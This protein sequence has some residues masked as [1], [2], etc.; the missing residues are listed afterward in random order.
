MHVEAVG[1]AQSGKSDHHAADFL[2]R[3]SSG[4]VEDVVDKRVGVVAFAAERLDKLQRLLKETVIALDSVIGDGRAEA[5]QQPRL[6]APLK[7]PCWWARVPLDDVVFAHRP[8]GVSVPT[9][10]TAKI[11]G[12]TVA[13]LAIRAWA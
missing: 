3:F 2:P 1:E 5:F 9:S 7:R 8:V 11:A 4:S 10:S 6:D 12:L 13:G